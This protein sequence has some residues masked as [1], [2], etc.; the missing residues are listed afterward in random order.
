MSTTFDC[1]TNYLI[2]SGFRVVIN[3]ENF[4]N[5]QFYAQ[6]VQHPSADLDNVEVSYPR[7]GTVPFIG[8]SITFGV[9]SM[10]VLVDENMRVYQEM[11]DWLVRATE[12]THKLQ[13]SR[14]SRSA[15]KI[16]SYHDVQVHILTS[17]NNVN[18][19][20]KYINCCPTGIGNINFQATTSEQY[21]TFPV[22]F[23]FDYFEFE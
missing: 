20:F 12:E 4:A 5:L 10:D 2:P 9:L 22:S 8:E 11:Y 7:A 16:A 19:S 15:P 1:G 23:R 17:H 6:T 13:T 3:R 18:H 14:F 21:T